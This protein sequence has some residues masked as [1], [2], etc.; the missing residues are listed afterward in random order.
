MTKENQLQFF[1]DFTAQQAQ[2]MLSKGDDYAGADRLSNFKK[3]AM[4]C[5]C[6]PELVILNLIA[7]KVA[8]LSELMSGKAPKNESIED[9]ML[10]LAN[11][12]ILLAMVRDDRKAEEARAGAEQF[13]RVNPMRKVQADTTME[14][15]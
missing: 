7:T 9:S 1:N 13:E 3:V 11:Y 12:T 14:V 2:I 5:N 10:D 8:R 4:M 15:E 6:S